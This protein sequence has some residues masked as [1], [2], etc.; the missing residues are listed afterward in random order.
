MTE[1]TGDRQ[2]PP[3]SVEGTVTGVL[4]DLAADGFDVSFI[5]GAEPGHLRCRACGSETAAER[6]EVRRERRLEGASD[7]DDMVLVVGARCPVCRRL[8][9]VVLGYGAEASP[10]DADLVLALRR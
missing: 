6:F 10:E 5:P 1:G 2:P 4:T 8:G 3:G 9:V 7:P